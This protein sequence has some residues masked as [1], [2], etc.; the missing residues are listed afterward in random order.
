MLCIDIVIC[1]AIF[2]LTLFYVRGWGNAM[3]IE[4]LGLSQYATKLCVFCQF[5]TSR[6]HATCYYSHLTCTFVADAF[7]RKFILRLF[8]VFLNVFSQ[9]LLF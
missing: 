8:F 5:N 4:I 9:G 1:V 2:Y 3:G 7:H 6:S